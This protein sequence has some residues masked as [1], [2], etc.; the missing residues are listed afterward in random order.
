MSGWV[1]PPHV[2]EKEDVHQWPD[3]RWD[4][5]KDEDCV[6]AAG[7]MQYLAL[8]PG[9]APATL[10]EAE[11]LRADAGIGP[12]GGSTSANLVTG[13]TKRYGWAPT[14]IPP[15]FSVLWSSLRPGMGATASGKPSD[16]SVGNPFKRFLSTYTGGHRVFIE[17]LNDTDNV[18]LMDPEGPKTGYTG[19]WASKAHLAEFVKNGSS[20][21]IAQ[22]AEV[23]EVLTITDQTPK[24]VTTKDGAVYYDPTSGAVVTKAG[25][26]QTRTSPYATA[27]GRCVVVHRSATN[28]DQ[29]LAVKSGDPAVAIAPAPAITNPT[30]LAA[31]VYKVG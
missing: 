22:L 31:G 25:S 9:A 7:L 21:T 8:H 24:L 15:G 13:T 5:A 27:I 11:A 10:T 12:A 30:P 17:R 3:G 28:T 1:K 4:D 14:I 18:W 16:C 19:Q 26:T 20:H 23:G 29:L 6:W 2:C